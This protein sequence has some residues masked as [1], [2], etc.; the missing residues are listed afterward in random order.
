MNSSAQH[1]ENN[2]NE[3][4]RSS[5]KVTYLISRGNRK[6]LRDQKVKKPLANGER[7]VYY[8][9]QRRTI[10]FGEGFIQFAEAVLRCSLPFSSEAL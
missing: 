8:E 4:T 3:S 5:N 2:R 6:N 9:R 7:C 1:V 10:F